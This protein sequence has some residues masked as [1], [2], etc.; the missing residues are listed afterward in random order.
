M[1]IFESNINEIRIILSLAMLG[2][3]TYWDLKSR[4]IS[5]FLWIVFGGISVVLIFFTPNLTNTLVTIGIS[6]IIAPIAIILWRLGLFGGADAFGLIVLAALS[7]QLSFSSGFVTPLTTLTNSAILSAVP[8]LLNI[9][10]NLIALARK[11]NIFDGFENETRR[12]KIFALFLGYR[13]KNPKFSFSIEKCDGSIK[14]LDF[15]LKNADSAEF[16]SSN[17][18]WV[19]PGIPYM[20]YIASGFVVQIVYGDIIFN[21]LKA[22]H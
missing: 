15:S 21:F 13:A 3:A 16:C 6:M 12:N 5:D 17:D 7:P 9:S 19:T 8:I 10:R 22:T 11:E 2:C 14:K 1:M 4:E 20:I 18:T